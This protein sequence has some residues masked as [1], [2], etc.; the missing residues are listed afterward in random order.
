MKYRKQLFVASQSGLLVLLA[1]LPTHSQVVAATID[2]LKARAYDYGNG[3]T[4]GAGAG[5]VA[6]TNGDDGNGDGDD[7]DEGATA[8]NP[9][10]NKLTSAA[11]HA[12]HGT[13]MAFAFV[14]LFPLGA[15]SQHFTFLGRHKLHLHVGCQLF[16]YALVLMGSILGIWLAVGAQD[17][18][19]RKYI[20]ASSI[21]CANL[22]L[23]SGSTTLT[24]SWDSV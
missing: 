21:R 16:G 23:G 3:N 11:V 2:Q 22:R 15:M 4:I 24:R 17:V 10:W 20:S 7:D 1:L 13:F 19:F 18:R 8:V 6:E 5:L 12:G 14:I 9:L